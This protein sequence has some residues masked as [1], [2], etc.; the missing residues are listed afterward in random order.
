MEKSELMRR[1]LGEHTFDWFLRNK[2]KEWERYQHH[3][4]RFE[5]ETY[6]PVL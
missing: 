6:L 5:L 1:A 4:S 2:R 3:V